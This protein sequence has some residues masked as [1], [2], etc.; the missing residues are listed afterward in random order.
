[1]LG[2]LGTLPTILF[3]G[4]A[5]QQMTKFLSNLTTFKA[6]FE[7]S[8]LDS[9]QRSATRTQGTF[10][11]KKPGRF[12]W[13]YSEPDAQQIIA[14]GDNVWLLEPDLKQV[15]VQGQKSALEG[16]PAML[17]ISGDPVD[18]HFETI[19]IGESKGFYWVELIPRSIESQFVRILLAF[20]QDQLQRME[21]TDQFGQI[22]RF[23]FHDIVL[24]S[25]LDDKLFIY[26]RPLDYDLYER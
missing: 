8:V 4:S 24:N 3:A 14:D 13:D 25:K 15:S 23:Q 1:M 21:M 16:T 22:S 10:Y 18:Q 19:D 17:L 6:G 26:E 5:E 20:H 12:R 7:Q 2:L 11:L 9:Q